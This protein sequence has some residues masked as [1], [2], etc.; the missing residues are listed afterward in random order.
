[1]DFAVTA[2]H[3]VKIKEKK[4]MA[5]YSDLSRELKK[6]AEHVND[7]DFNR[8]R[9]PKGDFQRPRNTLKELEMSGRIETIFPNQSTIKIN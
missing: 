1:M 5:K 4:T 8:C 3:R 7:S 9:Y 6:T 2:E